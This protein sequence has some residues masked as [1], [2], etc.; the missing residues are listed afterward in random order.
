MELEGSQ[1]R[2]AFFSPSPADT[3]AE[4]PFHPLWRKMGVSIMP[5]E[6]VAED[7][8][9]TI[10]KKKTVRIMGGMSTILFAKLNSI[11]PKLADAIMMKKYG[12]MLQP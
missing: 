1:A 5:V 7:L 3:E 8:L 4:R 2:V 11:S 6:K 12:K 9:K 10:E